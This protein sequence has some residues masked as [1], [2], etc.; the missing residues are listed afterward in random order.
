MLRDKKELWEQ[1]KLALGKRLCPG[2]DL[3]QWIQT[4]KSRSTG[5]TVERVCGVYLAL[6]VP[7]MGGTQK[8]QEKS[9]V[10]QM[11]QASEVE[12]APPGERV[13]T[14]THYMKTHS[15]TPNGHPKQ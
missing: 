8:K 6:S 1:N 14:P 15:K 7:A 9:L 11:S 3:G 2:G 13:A 5:E 4:T 12:M 10:S